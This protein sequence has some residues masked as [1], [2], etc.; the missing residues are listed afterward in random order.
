MAQTWGEFKKKIAE[1]NCK[2]HYHLL[3]YYG[4]GIGNEDYSRLVFAAGN[5]AEPIID[6]PVADLAT[7][8]SQS[9]YQP[10]LA[11]I[12]CCQGDTAGLLGA[13]HQLL[14]M[15]PVVVT[16][17]TVARIDAARQ[18]AMVFWKATLLE[19]IPP[20]TAISQMYSRLGDM[21]LT[22]KDVRWMTPVLHS[23]YLNWKAK[24][25][26]RHP[27][28]HNTHWQFRVDRT[29][30]VNEVVGSTSKMLRS[31][32]PVLRFTFGMEK[33]VRV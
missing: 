16:N 20:H 2:K 17:R 19:R 21:N 32:I 31:V 11:Y 25:Y 28:D 8:L 10:L 24:P 22:L 7:C 6:R 26:P 27:P 30:Q 29:K 18:Q 9:D 5:P 3:Y 1:Q 12:N 4:H 23:R 15:I 13:G 14:R 33:K